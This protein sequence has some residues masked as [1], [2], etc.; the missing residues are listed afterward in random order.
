MGLA[1]EAKPVVGRILRCEKNKGLFLNPR[2]VTLLP[3]VAVCIKYAL[4]VSQVKVEPKTRKPITAGVP[5]KISDFDKNAIEEAVRIKEKYGGSVTLIAMAP[6]DAKTALKEGLAMGADEAYLLSD[7]AFSFS[8]AL[9]TS[10]VLSEAL[11]KLGPFDLIL[12]G[13]TSIDGYSYQVGPRIAGLLGIPQLTYVRRLSVEGNSVIAERDLEDGYEVVK[14]R[15]P[16]LVTVTK[17]VNEP[18]V[19]TLMAIMKAS[20]KEIK[21]LTI[22]DLGIPKEKVGEQGSGIRLIDV[23]APEVKRK[24]LIVKDKPPAEAARILAETLVKEGVVK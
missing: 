1:L 19:P 2:V 14:A 21:T 17:E 20:R 11:K 4:D 6:P 5:R 8:D 12:C 13:E 15:M 9:V 24:G 16:V 23:Y 10:Y 7:P 3:K 22:T 18:R